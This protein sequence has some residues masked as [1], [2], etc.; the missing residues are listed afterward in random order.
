M[1]KLVRNVPIV[2][3]L[4]MSSFCRYRNSPPAPTARPSTIV[5]C[6]ENPNRGTLPLWPRNSCALSVISRNGPAPATSTALC[7]KAFMKYACA[8][9]A[10]TTAGLAAKHVIF[11]RRSAARAQAGKPQ[12]RHSLGPHVFTIPDFDVQLLYVLRLVQG[13]NRTEQLCIETLAKTAS[14]CLPDHRITRS[15]DHPI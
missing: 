5:P 10:F 15:L 8:K 6:L 3:S 1:S 11:R 2:N 9:T 12:L 13:A 4:E 7:A 14:V